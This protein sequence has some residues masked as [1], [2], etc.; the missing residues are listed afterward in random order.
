MMDSNTYANMVQTGSASSCDIV[1]GEI[2]TMNLDE[3][4][5]D[6][7]NSIPSMAKHIEEKSLDINS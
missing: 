7:I 6:D 3:K 5:E 4:M 1:G 2:S